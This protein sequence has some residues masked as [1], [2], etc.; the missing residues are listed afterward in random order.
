MVAAGHYWEHDAPV[1]WPPPPLT[2]DEMHARCEVSFKGPRSMIYAP[3]L[4]S[5]AGGIRP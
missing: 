5:F 3:G 2:I 1:R 4:A